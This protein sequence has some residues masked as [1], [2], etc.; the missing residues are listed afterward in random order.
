MSYARRPNTATSFGRTKGEGGMI[1]ANK[2][3]ATE[4][5]NSLKTLIPRS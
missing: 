3:M 1:C 4:S 2:N 5:A